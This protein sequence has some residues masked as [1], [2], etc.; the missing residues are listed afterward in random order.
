M[1]KI[2]LNSKTFAVPLD[3]LEPDE[4]NVRLTGREIDVPELAH[5]IAHEGLL[6]GLGVRPVLD[7]SGEP[8]GRYGVVIGGRRLAALRLLVKKQRL[9]KDEPVTCFA[10]KPAAL[11]SAGLAENL[12]RLAM[13]PADA[14]VAFARMSGEGLCDAEIAVRFGLSPSTVQKRLRLGR[15]SPALLDALRANRISEPVA[16]AFA[17]TDD[18]EAQQRVYAKVQGREWIDPQIVRSMLTE[19]E[20]P[21]HDRRVALIGL[22]AYEQAGGGVRRDLFADEPGG[23]VTLTDPGLLDRLVLEK[24]AAEGDRLRADGWRTVS[25]SM[26]P[27]EDMR[28]FYAAP[29]DREPLPEDAD[30]R[31]TDLSEQYDTLVEQGEAEGLTDEE[32]E[33][34][35]AIQA[36]ITAIEEATERY[37]DETKAAG[38]VFVF[39]SD[40]ELRV[41]KGL[42]RA[43]QAQTASEIGTAEDDDEQGAD[44]NLSTPDHSAI[45]KPE[46]SAMLTAE[47]QA[48]RTAA[49][50]ARVAQM[51][52]LALRLVVHSLLLG[53]GHGGYRTVAQISGHEP[54]LQQA[55]RTIEDTEAVRT[56]TAMHDRRGDH[57]PGEHADLLPWLLSLDN[58]EVLNVLAPLVASTVDAGSED[59][60]QGAGRSLAAGVATAARLNMTD[61]W[62]PTVETYFGRVTKMQIG[63]AV[64]EAGAGPFNTEG[65]KAEVAA[66]AARLVAGTDWLPAMLRGPPE[67]NGDVKRS[68]A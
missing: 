15:L 63:Q 39:L 68:T 61:W 59:W 56:V 35:D 16:Q 23:G 25:V 5:N 34:L 29:F 28:G 66:A 64:T 46:L 40:S 38:R 8:T 31:L 26:M 21:S 65:K 30:R 67:G 47:L 53:R 62:T 18:T 43:G 51:P 4:R 9:A 3:K 58:G 33:R 52:D 11:T 12:H 50:Q 7:D 36:E 10:V 22:A 20:V 14:Y 24:L 27:S 57:E 19:G 54:N 13:H 49:L 45:K 37:S 41:V 6:H 48:H 60:S 1:T 55:C 32:E 17:I 44:D 2:T 42:P